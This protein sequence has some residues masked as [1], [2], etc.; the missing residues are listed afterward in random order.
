[1]I[2]NSNICSG[3]LSIRRFALVFNDFCSGLLVELSN[4]FGIEPFRIFTV[5]A[6]NLCLLARTLFSFCHLFPA[7]RAIIDHD[8]LLFPYCFRF[9]CRCSHWLIP[10]P[11]PSVSAL[12]LSQ[13]STAKWAVVD[14]HWK[15][16]LPIPFKDHNVFVVPTV[17]GTTWTQIYVCLA[18]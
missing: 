9:P 3:L 18:L 17:S 16:F 7:K 10:G 6:H 4:I 11:R 14:F 13:F 12:V 5:F 1:M 8:F 15:V 2:T